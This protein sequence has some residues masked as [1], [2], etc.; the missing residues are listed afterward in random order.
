MSEDRYNEKELGQILR[1]AAAA[2][3][4]ASAQVDGDVDFSVQDISSMAAEVGIDPKYVLEAAG[5]IADKRPSQQGAFSDVFDKTLAGILSDQGWQDLVADL[6]STFGS[7]GTTDSTEMS[8]EWSGGH[9]LYSVHMSAIERDG[10]TKL[11]LMLNRTGGL[12]FTWALGVAA[13]FLITVL[14]LIPLKAL[15]LAISPALTMP[16]VAFATFMA[17]RNGVQ[18][19]TSQTRAKAKAFVSGLELP[20]RRQ[21]T[22]P[23]TT[24]EADAEP[25]VQRLQNS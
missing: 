5:Q 23:A 17:I 11:R 3:A 8:R 1:I 9:E 6:Q 20:T 24:R 13:I 12:Y 21:E 10:K 18:R 7:V 16:L 15:G 25:L 4:K 19:W 14:S 2:Q 22:V